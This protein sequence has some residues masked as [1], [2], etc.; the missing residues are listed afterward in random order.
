MSRRVRIYDANAHA[1]KMRETFVDRPVER[2]IPYDID[3][4]VVMQNVGDSLAVAYASDKWQPKTRDGKRLA[5]LYKHLAESRNR[6]LAREGVLVDYYARSKRWPVI[7][8]RVSF[9]GANLWMPDTFALLGRFEEIDLC[10]HTTGTDD[11][12]RFGSHEDDGVV[13][14]SVR[15]GYLGGSMMKAGRRHEPFLFVFTKGDGVMFIVLGEQL[16]IEKDGIVG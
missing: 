5:E 11:D 4:P 6:C 15:H 14:V 13:H 7:G 9:D 2:E 3:W 1:R 16:G 8:P 10:L 12:P